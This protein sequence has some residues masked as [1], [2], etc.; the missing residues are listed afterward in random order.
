VEV[1][2]FCLYHFGLSSYYHKGMRVLE[3]WI[4]NVENPLVELGFSLFDIKNSGYREL[5]MRIRMLNNSKG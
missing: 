2:Q 3:Q 1:R 4:T 5:L